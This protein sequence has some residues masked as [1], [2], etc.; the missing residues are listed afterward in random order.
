MFQ[1]KARGLSLAHK[2]GG[3]L[4]GVLE[5]NKS[6]SHFTFQDTQAIPLEDVTKYTLLPGNDVFYWPVRFID[7]K[8]PP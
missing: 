3:L 7:I 5:K 8:P 4:C 2:R 1:R 6:D